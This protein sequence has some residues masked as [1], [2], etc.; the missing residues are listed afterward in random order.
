MIS[1]SWNMYSLYGLAHS[2]YKFPFTAPAA[3]DIL[4]AMEKTEAAS[5]S[6]EADNGKMNE[7]IYTISTLDLVWVLIPAGIVV[8]VF[9]RWSLG[10]V[11]ILHGFSRMFIQLLLVG[12]ALSYIFNAD[13]TL[14]V[15]ADLN[16]M[17]FAAAMIS[18]RPVSA[19]RSGLYLKA[20]AAISVGGILTLVIV[21]QAVIALDPW[22]DPRYVIPLAGMIFANSMNAVS[23]VSAVTTYLC[24]SSR[25]ASTTKT[26]RPSSATHSLKP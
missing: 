4:T 15:V 20:L 24:P 7:S 18:L 23:I 21:T 2:F 13:Q 5:P 26:R 3:I 19:K 6:G 8:A 9:V 10:T 11:S 12:Y 1:L 16:V 17:L 22:Y 14:I 25:C